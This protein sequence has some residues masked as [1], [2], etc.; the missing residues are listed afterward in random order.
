MG[1]SSGGS[2]GRAIGFPPSLGGAARTSG[3][4]R[5]ILFPH[6]GY[7]RHG[8][9][10]IQPA[11]GAQGQVELFR[12]DGEAPFQRRLRGISSKPRQPPQVRRQA[13]ARGVAAGVVVE[14]LHHV[15]GVARQIVEV[16]HERP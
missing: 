16:L 14:L 5:K 10:D 9:T 4:Q 1:G 13:G 3:G 12:D 8:D 15:A 2:S 6:R 11:V 7:D